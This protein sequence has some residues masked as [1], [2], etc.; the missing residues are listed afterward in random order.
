M[1]D[2]LHSQNNVAKVLCL[3]RIVWATLHW[4]AEIGSAAASNCQM[5]SGENRG[6]DS[7]GSYSKRP[8]VVNCD[9][10]SS[11]SAQV[12]LEMVASV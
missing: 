3:H 5:L 1:S 11:R 9:Q 10:M 4:R 7:A 8:P 2:V 12:S 6:A